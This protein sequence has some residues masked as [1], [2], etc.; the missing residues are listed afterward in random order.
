MTDFENRQMMDP[1][2][3]PMFSQYRSDNNS[4]NIDPTTRS[5]ASHNIE[6][7]PQHPTTMK[8]SSAILLA[9]IAAS[10]GLPSSVAADSRR[11]SMDSGRVADSKL[12]ATSL[13]LRKL[14]EDEE[15]DEVEMEVEEPEEETEDEEN[16]DND[17]DKEDTEEDEG[18][19]EDT[20]DEDEDTN[21]DEGEEETEAESTDE[22]SEPESADEEDEVAEAA[23][24][25][26]ERVCEYSS[27]YFDV[28]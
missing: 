13:R 27:K 4:H 12:A 11:V 7:A 23:M 26:E 21:E 24:P 17:E 20:E 2:L 6:P 25:T 14:Q 16:V 1:S 9:A 10:I 8:F 19:E 15:E 5:K 18:E 22:D 28:G 3:T